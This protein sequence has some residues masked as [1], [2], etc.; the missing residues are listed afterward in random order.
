MQIRIKR[1]HGKTWATMKDEDFV[2]DKFLKKI[3]VILVESIVFEAGKDFAK[4]GSRPTPIGHPEGIPRTLRF[5]DSFGYRV[6]NSSIEIYSTWPWIDQIIKGRSPYPMEWLTKEAGVNA[7]PMRQPDGTVLIRSTPRMAKDAWI[8]PGFA[9]NNF[10][11]RGYERARRQM[12][13]EL[14]KQ[15]NKV[16]AGMSIA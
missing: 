6:K 4:Q 13:A 15:V 9:K 8:H 16:L 1:T 3:G 12:A 5:F 7:V 11:R 14:K 2:D 10:V